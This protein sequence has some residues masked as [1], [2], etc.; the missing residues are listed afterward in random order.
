[1][2]DGRPSSHEAGTFFVAAIVVGQGAWSIAHHAGR[3]GMLSNDHLF[4]IWAASVSA[5]IATFVIGRTA[6]GE[7]YASGFS[8][9]LLGLP[10]V[11]FVMEIYLYQSQAYLTGWFRFALTVLMV[12]V[13]LPYVI[14]LILISALPDVAERRHKR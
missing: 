6:E 14:Y 13:S 10:S 3:Y 1:M 2:S 8:T 12:T 11:W 4:A 9:M 7:K 5:L